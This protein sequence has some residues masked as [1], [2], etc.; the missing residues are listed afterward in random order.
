MKAEFPGRPRRRRPE[1]EP[2]SACARLDAAVDVPWVLLSS[3]ATFEQ[4]RGQVRIAAAAGACGFMAGRAI[5][6][7]AVGRYDADRRRGS[8]RP[9]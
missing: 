3:S 5:W 1:A 7:D 9:P 4:F 2:P 6:G 8:A